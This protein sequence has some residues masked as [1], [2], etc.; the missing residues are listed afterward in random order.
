M[1]GL[2]QTKQL[3]HRQ[4]IENWMLITATDGDIDRLDSFQIDRIDPDWK[5]GSWIEPYNGCG[6]PKCA[7]GAGSNTLGIG[8]RIDNILLA[9][10]DI[11][12]SPDGK[13]LTSANQGGNV[14][15]I[16]IPH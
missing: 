4:V 1:D 7:L 15:N 3:E 16:D 14:L 12:H 9:H 6:D 8:G 2:S 5:R 10:P 11:Y 13:P